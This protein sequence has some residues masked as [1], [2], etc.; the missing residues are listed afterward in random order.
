[1]RFAFCLAGGATNLCSIHIHLCAN[2]EVGNSK[3]QLPILFC[4]EEAGWYSPCSV[5]Y[6][7]EANCFILL[8]LERQ[9]LC[10]CFF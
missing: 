6:L 7:F 1:M 4:R 10:F 2:M 3:L 5:T 8:T 9:V